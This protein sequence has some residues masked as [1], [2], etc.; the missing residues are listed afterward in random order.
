MSISLVKIV[1]RKLITDHRGWF[2]KFID[3]KEENLPPY[4][5][6]IY[7]TSA[8]PLEKKGGHYH[9]KAN[10]WF[11]PV[12]GKGTLLLEDIQTK[13][14]L[15]VSMDATNPVTVFVPANVA[16]IVKNI[17]TKENFILCAYTDQYYVPEDT[18]NYEF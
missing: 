13:E 1:E 16:H 17:S 5:G 4:T 11:C 2:M 7:F 9:I 14:R 6:E 3:G 10:E 18:I 12:Y 15:S 8:N